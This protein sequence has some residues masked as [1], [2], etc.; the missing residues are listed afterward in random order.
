MSH[1]TSVPVPV[2]V[3][4]P[5]LLLLFLFACAPEPAERTY[6]FT[7]LDVGATTTRPPRAKSNGQFLRNV[8]ADALGRAP[9]PF[10][11]TASVSGTE[12]LRLPLDEE[13]QLTAALDGVS[14]VRPLRSI[15]ITALL[16]SESAN[17]PVK[18]AIED[19]AEYIAAQFRRVLGREPNPYELDAFVTAWRDDAAV[20]PRVV[21]SALFESREYQS[22]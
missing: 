7:S 2:P 20:G 8:Y 22:D 1:G 15:L 10:E 19:P 5:A 21:L 13:S 16:S 3:P 17:L 12:V 11:F 14:D 9:E 6:E 4:A 18:S